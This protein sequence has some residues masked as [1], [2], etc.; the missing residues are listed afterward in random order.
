MDRGRHVSQTVLSRRTLGRAVARLG[1]V[2][3]AAGLAA[4]L[5]AGCGLFE[6][7]DPRDA[8][9]TTG[10]RCRNR[11]DPDSLYDNIIVHYGQPSSG[12]CYADMIGDAFLF[13]PDV[14][15]YADAPAPPNNPYDGWN[16]AIEIG[17]TTNIKSTVQFIQVSFDST[18]Q[19]ATTTTNPTTET[20]YYHYHVLYRQT[21]QSDTTRF[22]GLADITTEQGAGS[23]WTIKAWRDQRDGS[24]FDTWGILRAN[25]RGG[26]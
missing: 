20:R 21:G 25:N 8:D 17:V 16:R 24:G 6:P 1:L 26:L 9:G 7:R 18:Y 5:V 12:S 4:A 2:A 11:S 15:D 14:Q 22:Q 19:P 3:V 23:L 10:P 13:T